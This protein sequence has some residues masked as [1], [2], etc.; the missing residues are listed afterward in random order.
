VREPTGIGFYTLALLRELAARR[1][2]DLLALSHRPP[3]I[4]AELADLGIAVEVEPAPLGVIWQQLRLPARLQ[5]GDIDLL[6][7]PLLTLPRR[8]PVPAV[9]TL[10]D[11]AVLHV[12]ETLPWKVR[13]SLVPFLE[14][15][16]ESASRIVVSTRR[17]AA[18]LEAA[19]PAA[20]GRWDL[21]SPGVDAAFRPLPS[22]E[23]REIRGQYGAPSGYLLAI[24]TLEPRKNLELLLDAWQTLR[25][26]EA[27]N[28][29]P[30]FLVGPEGWKDGRLR[31]R[32]AALADD[33]V[34]SFGR[35]ESDELVR[36]L[37]GSIGLVYPSIYEGFGLPVAEALACGR[38]AVVAAET[39]PAEVAGSAGVGFERDSADDLAAALLRLMALD[40]DPEAERRALTA[41]GPLTW[42][43]AAEALSD[44]L[45]R[46]LEAGSR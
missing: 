30:L 39:S 3:A 6:W 16:V 40:T 42:P 32:V 28:A 27:E 37:Q 35:V 2:F 24:G 7:S 11:L 19:F 15:T 29:P 38:C 41:A 20:R 1:E 43:R 33:G 34:R 44:V 17:V 4:A 12:P 10:Q 23:R 9:V 14:R 21:V 31:R 46:A 8:L 45:R 26:Q 13:W 5:R 36:L 18:E 25:A 22:D